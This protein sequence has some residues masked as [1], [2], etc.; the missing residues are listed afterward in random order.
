M[1]ELTPCRSTLKYTSRNRYSPRGLLSKRVSAWLFPSG[2]RTPQCPQRFWVRGWRV[3]GGCAVVLTR[4]VTTC[5][6]VV[7][8][9]CVCVFFCVCMC[10]CV[11]VCLCV[12]ACVR[13]CV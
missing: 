13:S 1:L 10:L 12:C 5:A 7:L 8:C 11:F 9:W 3:S 2:I 6:R 4:V